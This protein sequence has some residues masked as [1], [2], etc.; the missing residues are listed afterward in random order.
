MHV[1]HTSCIVMSYHLPSKAAAK[2]SLIPHAQ[3]FHSY[4]SLCSAVL[5]NSLSLSLVSGRDETLLCLYSRRLWP[6]MDRIELTLSFSDVYK[7]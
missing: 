1:A 7:L 2:G 6:Q 5:Q 3:G 4:P